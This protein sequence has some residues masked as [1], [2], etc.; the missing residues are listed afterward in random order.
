M[1]RCTTCVFLLTL[2]FCAQRMVEPALL[3]TAIPFRFRLRSGFGGLMEMMLRANRRQFLAIRSP[4]N[5]SIA[6]SL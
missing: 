4:E 1:L 5:R 3:A 2:P 6:H